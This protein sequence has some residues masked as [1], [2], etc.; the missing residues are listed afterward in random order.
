MKQLPGKPLGLDIVP[1]KSPQRA[2]L[3][4][5]RLR[6]LSV[7]ADCFSPMLYHHVLGFSTDWI[8][9]IL[10]D[11]A[12]Q[13]DKPLIPFVQVDAFSAEDGP[14]SARDWER[15]LDAVLSHGSLRR[16]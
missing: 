13:T 2:R 7:Y 16:A 15:V 5:Q 14:F 12:A 8:S 10:D 6:D 3:L 11:M 4:G 1:A 9:E